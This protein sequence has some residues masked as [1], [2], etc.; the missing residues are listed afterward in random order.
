M[1]YSYPHADVRASAERAITVMSMWGNF[2]D[3]RRTARERMLDEFSSVS[4]QPI[5]GLFVLIALFIACAVFVSKTSNSSDVM[6]MFGH[7]VPLRS[8]TGAFSAVCNMCVVLMIVLY[9]APGFYIS[10]SMLIVQLPMLFMNLFR[11]NFG[12]ISGIVTDIVI[13]LIS[14]Y[15]FKYVS[16]SFR[17]QQRM[18]DQAST[19][20]IT[21][22]PNSF[23]TNELMRYMIQKKEPF[24]LAVIKFVNFGNINNT[25]GQDAGDDVLVQ[26]GERMTRVSQSGSAGA[27]TFVATR[28]GNEFLLVIRDCFSERTA[29]MVIDHFA[30]TLG[31]KFVVEGCDFVL[32][33]SVGYSMYPEDAENEKTVFD[34]AYVAMEQARKTGNDRSVLRFSETMLN[35]DNSVEVERT[36]R[37]ALDN[38]NVFYNLQP[39]FDMDHKLRG[40][41]ALARLRDE[42]GNVMSPVVFI[43]V[44]EKTGLVDLI[45]TRVLFS[46]SKF[47]GELVRKTGSDLVLSVNASVRHLMQA[48]FVDELRRALDESGLPPQQLEVEITESIMIESVEKALECISQITALGVGIS[49][50]DF[51]TGFSSLSY[52]NSLPSDVIKVDRSFI[53]TMNTSEKS[54]Q[55]VAAIIALG[56]IMNFKVVAEGVENDEQIE[57]LRNIGCDYIQGFVWGRPMLPADA[58]KLVTG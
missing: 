57:T 55:Y 39:Q 9:R 44:A 19:D 50:D 21:G 10:V 20:R 37:H 41:E 8:V 7:P 1:L 23:A 2:L 4:R 47:L 32:S 3:R 17:F 46:A 22:I 12:A 33:T 6:F 53:T 14:A 40:F 27:K 26:I 15:L 35:N 31:E 43:P 49:I 13:I 24:V 34:Y 56:H 25:L 29:R 5:W 45:D 18:R 28:K 54:K 58:A 48:G 38:G 42:E 51:G 11:Q 30:A 36:I 16:R 52:L